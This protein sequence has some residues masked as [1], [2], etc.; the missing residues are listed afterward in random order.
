MCVCNVCVSVCVR[1]CV[2]VCMYVCVCVCMCVCVCV[3]VREKACLVSRKEDWDM[4]EWSLWSN[5]TRWR[6][7]QSNEFGERAVCILFP[8]KTDEVY[9]Q[10]LTRQTLKWTHFAC[11]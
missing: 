7:H 6:G 4:G 11:K 10:K 3:C 1:V 9:F 8:F 5:C 2:Y